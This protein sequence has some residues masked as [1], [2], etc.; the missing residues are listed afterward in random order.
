MSRR[1]VWLSFSDW[2]FIRSELKTKNNNSFYLN[3]KEIKQWKQDINMCG[4]DHQYCFERCFIY[5]VLNE[6][7]SSRTRNVL[8]REYWRSQDFHHVMDFNYEFIGFVIN[9]IDDVDMNTTM[10]EWEDIRNQMKN[11]MNKSDKQ[12]WFQNDLIKLYQQVSNQTVA[13]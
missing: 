2:E 7:I 1:N 5:G 9:Y 6:D 3:E 11:E 8:C 13:A 4:S 10:E 12:Y